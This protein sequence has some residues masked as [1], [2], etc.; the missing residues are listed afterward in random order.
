MG[1]RLERLRDAVGAPPAR[2]A[3]VLRLVL[4]VFGLAFCVIVAL[5]TSDTT[6]RIILW[7]V[8]VIAVVNVAVVLLRLWQ[9]HQQDRA[10]RPDPGRNGRAGD[11]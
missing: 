1:S 7:V 2:S 10:G 11:G 8:A 6:I 9:R 3:L 4:A 5:L